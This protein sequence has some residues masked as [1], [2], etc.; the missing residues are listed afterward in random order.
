[1]AA[2]FGPVVRLTPA[3]VIRKFTSRY[4]TVD[5]LIARDTLTRPL[6]DFLAE[7]IRAGKML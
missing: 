6:A 5:D 1:L 4:Y 3:L 2:V 7:Q